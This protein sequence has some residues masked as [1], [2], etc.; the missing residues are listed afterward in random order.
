MLK[1]IP[2]FFVNFFFNLLFGFSNV[3]ILFLIG[4]TDDFEKT[5]P[6]Q[7]LFSF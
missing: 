3:E 1:S 6:F 7:S 5:L 2:T 4:L